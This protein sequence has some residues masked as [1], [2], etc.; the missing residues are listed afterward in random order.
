MTLLVNELIKANFQLGGMGN[1]PALAE[2]PGN[3]V[4]DPEECGERAAHQESALDIT[5]KGL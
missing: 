4:Q 5:A 2:A 3:G 1:L